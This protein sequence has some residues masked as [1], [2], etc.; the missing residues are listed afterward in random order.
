MC[1][2]G[3]PDAP[4]WPTTHSRVRY[5]AART[6]PSGSRH[7]RPPRG[8][9]GYPCDQG[10]DRGGGAGSGT[11]RMAPPRSRP[12]VPTCGKPINAHQTASNTYEDDQSASP[13][14]KVK[15]S[16]LDPPKSSTARA[17]HVYMFENLFIIMLFES[18]SARPENR[19]ARTEKCM[20]R[21]HM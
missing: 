7:L 14:L 1:T 20:G 4:R 2:D 18:K 19:D 12:P 8:C 11:W 16:Y 17:P 3:I 15:R 5:A 13:V 21:T 10:R 6:K 9:P